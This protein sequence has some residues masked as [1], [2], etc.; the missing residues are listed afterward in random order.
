MKVADAGI[1]GLHRA[2]R[3]LYRDGSG[4]LALFY[5]MRH[6]HLTFISVVR[7][8]VTRLGWLALLRQVVDLS[9]LVALKAT[10]ERSRLALAR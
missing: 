9:V 2:M 5:R 4:A 3:D 8:Q 6:L 7:V 10:F 1:L